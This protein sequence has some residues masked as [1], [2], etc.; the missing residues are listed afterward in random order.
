MLER[1]RERCITLN[2]IVEKSRFKYVEV[3][4]KVEVKV[5]SKLKDVEKEEKTIRL[6]PE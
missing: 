3:E 5:K 2:E 6:I 4:E 1:K